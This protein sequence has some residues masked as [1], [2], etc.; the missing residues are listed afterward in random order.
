[1]AVVVVRF[2]LAYR[3]HAAVGHFT[4]HALELD[5]SVVDAEAVVQTVFYVAQDAFAD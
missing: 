2:G 5:G 3:H 1:M 4:V